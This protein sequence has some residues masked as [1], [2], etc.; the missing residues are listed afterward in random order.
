MSQ[1][2]LCAIGLP[3]VVLLGAGCGDEGE[4]AGV[5][6]AV[7]M[8]DAAPTMADAALPDAA[9]PDAAA[10]S[11]LELAV[12]AGFTGTTRRLLVVLSRTM[13]LAGPPAGILL[14]ED[15][16]VLSAGGVRT[17]QLDTSAT[18]GGPFYIVAVLFMQGGGQQ[19]PMAGVDYAGYSTRTFTFAGAAQELGRVDLALA[20]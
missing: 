14:S 17:L 19:A 5:D 10:R 3:L 15:A 20:R 18:Q 6:A 12:P 13:P 4:A 9:A 8:T 16:P 7:A 1:R 2:L 11:R